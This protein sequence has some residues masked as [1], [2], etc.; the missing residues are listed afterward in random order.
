MQGTKDDNIQEL[1]RHNKTTRVLLLTKKFNNKCKIKLFNA[2][3]EFHTLRSILIEK[4]KLQ[5]LITF[6]LH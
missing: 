4:N 1:V 3:T 5:N 6:R 2:Q